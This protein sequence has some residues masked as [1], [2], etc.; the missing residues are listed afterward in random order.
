MKRMAQARQ[1]VADLF[2]AQPKEIIFTASGTESDNMALI[3][4]IEALGQ[5]ENHLITSAIE[6]PAILE[7]T[8]LSGSAGHRGDVSR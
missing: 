5:R 2:N 6:H 4:V 7:T 8:P 3:G 1:Q